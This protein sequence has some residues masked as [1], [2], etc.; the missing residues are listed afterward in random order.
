MCV[1]SMTIYIY[2]HIYMY[3]YIYI[4]IY[5]YMRAA[6]VLALCAASWESETKYSI[7]CG[8][9]TGES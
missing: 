2:I 7:G 3:T 6:H 5:V 4:Y 1:Y 9:P 8:V